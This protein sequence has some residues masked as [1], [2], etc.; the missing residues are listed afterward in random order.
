[1][2]SAASFQAN[3]PPGKIS[4]KKQ[5]TKTGERCQAKSLDKTFSYAGV[6]LFSPFAV[7]LDYYIIYITVIISV[8]DKWISHQAE[9]VIKL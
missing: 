4:N 2:D 6:R 1:M 9:T 5:Y 7:G 3:K 8:V